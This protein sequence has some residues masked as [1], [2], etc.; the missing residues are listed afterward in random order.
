MKQF[1]IIILSM[2]VLFT[3]SCTKEKTELV[4]TNNES[5]SVLP[6]YE[7]S[8]TIDYTTKEN[9][10]AKITVFT[11]DKANFPK[12]VKI[13]PIY[14]LPE[15]NQ[16][17]NADVRYENDSLLNDKPSVWIDVT[18]VKL[19]KAAKGFKINHDAGGSKAYTDFAYSANGVYGASVKKTNSSGSIRAKIGVLWEG[20]DWF[21]SWLVNAKLKCE[22]C[23]VGCYP[24]SSFY[25]MAIKVTTRW[26]G[27]FDPKFY[28]E[29]TK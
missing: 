7:Y 20:S 3:F 8:T 1:S 23:Y 15:M 17:G 25:K 12:N 16:T 5:I 6:E 14:T 9:T 11:D 10:S 26:G 22:D 19:P 27:T 2:L 21:Y 18:N 13:I 4:D 29:D 28:Y 24:S